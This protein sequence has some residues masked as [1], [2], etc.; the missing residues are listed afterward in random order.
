MGQLFCCRK[1][2]GNQLKYDQ[3]LLQINRYVNNND[4][5]NN[6]KNKKNK[7]N[8]IFQFEEIIQNN[9]KNL[10]ENLFPIN[11]KFIM[12]FY[13]INK[14]QKIIIERK[15]ESIKTLEGLSELNHNNNLYLCGSSSL[16]PESE[17]GSH[18]FQLNPLNPETKILPKAKY[19]HYYPALISIKKNYIYCIGGKSQ[20]HCEG[21]NIN[22]NKWIPLP[23]LPEERYLC[24]LCYDELNNIIYLFGGINDKNHLHKDK[25]SIE[26]DYFLRLKNDI[27]NNNNSAIWEKI[28]VRNNKILLN[29]ISAASLIFENEEKYIYI[30]GGKDDQK[31]YLDNVIKFDIEEQ[32]FQ[33]IDQK[34]DFPT[35][36]LNQ[37]AIKSDLNNF[38]YVFLD[39]FNN[40]II[41]DKHNFVDFK[42]DDS[43]I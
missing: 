34:L 15:L 37:Y 39:K 5:N 41:I 38:I 2:D 18:F 26:Y 25:L 14:N 36:F 22:E 33:A 17:E 32:S 1:V 23:N 9:N 43:K 20:H 35:E 30:F 16:I 8:N 6:K 13:E 4:S 29:R 31:H 7:K 19:P 11:S 3:Y 12:I 28:H 21:Y 24:T 42:S 40:P 27:D 10:D